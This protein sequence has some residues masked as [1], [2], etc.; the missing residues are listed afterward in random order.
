LR[1]ALAEMLS[2]ENQV[3]LVKDGERYVGVLTL[4]IIGKMLRSETDA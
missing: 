2:S 1:D 3:A 4:S